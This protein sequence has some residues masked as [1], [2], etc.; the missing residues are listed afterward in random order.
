MGVLGV[1]GIRVGV[2]GVGGI[3]V[4]VVGV[5]EG[6][7]QGVWRR[8]LLKEKLPGGAAATATNSATNPSV[9]SNPLA[10]CSRRRSRKVTVR[11]LL[12]RNKAVPWSTS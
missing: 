1:G 9:S 6:L 3:R 2:V 5:Y 10:V 11:W 8:M 7:S 12:R 4:G